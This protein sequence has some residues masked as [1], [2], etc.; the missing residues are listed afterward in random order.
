[1]QLDLDELKKVILRGKLLTAKRVNIDPYSPP[2]EENYAPIEEEE[3]N[4]PPLR[5]FP[6]IK[7]EQVT[8]K[9]ESPAEKLA[10]VSAKVPLREDYKP[11]LLRKI[12]GGIVGGLVGIGSG[13][14]RGAE[15]GGGIVNAPYNRAYEDWLREQ[16]QPAQKEYDI[17]EASKKT[18]I[19][20]MVTMSQIAER[21]NRITT[22]TPEY[23]GRVAGAKKAGE[24]EVETPYKESLFNMEQEGKEALAKAARTGRL[25]EIDLRNKGA[26]D[27]QIERLR[28][29]HDENTRKIQSA[30]KIARERN[31][32]R[33]TELE[34]RLKSEG[35]VH[36]NVSPSEFRT[37]LEN[38]TRK[39]GTNPERFGITS[40]EA[41]EL[42]DESYLE[43]GQ[44]VLKPKSDIDENYQDAWDQLD[45][46]IDKEVERELAIT[47]TRPK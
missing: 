16:V 22:S 31:A 19:G 40:D 11:S 35:L 2:G 43:Q 33:A 14:E 38:A 32:A 30:E 12:G 26:S 24:L 21:L 15:L 8:V 25:D 1:M 9:Q 44:Y 34:K 7:S 3:T 39:V 13:A 27:L 46:E 45:D 20:N 17:S 10:R 23:Q 36:S 41:K 42:F 5:E 28:S 18:D 29:E 37:A 4:L 6:T 47:K